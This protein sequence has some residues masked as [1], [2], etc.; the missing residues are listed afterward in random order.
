MSISS[1]DYKKQRTKEEKKERRLK[2]KAREAHL[3]E[4]TF[5]MQYWFNTILISLAIGIFSALGYALVPKSIPT[6]TWLSVGLGVLIS[7]IYFFWSHR[8]RVK[9]IKED[10]RR[11]ARIQDSEV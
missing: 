11:W 1:S 7:A 9:R 2:N 6:P 5:T 8:S 4:V 10:V 3:R